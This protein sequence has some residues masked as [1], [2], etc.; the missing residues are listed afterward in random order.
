MLFDNLS[1]LVRQHLYLERL[2]DNEHALLKTLP[3]N[4][5]VLDEASVT[6]RSGLK[7]RAA[8]ATWT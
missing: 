8:S 1:D 4:C 3:P 5:E 7:V 2:G 6:L